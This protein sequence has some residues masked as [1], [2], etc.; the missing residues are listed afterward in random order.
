MHAEMYPE[1]D[2]RS[3]TAPRTSPY[4]T[5]RHVWFTR[6]VVA[7]LGR[8]LPRLGPFVFSSGP[9]LCRD[10]SDVAP[11]ARSP[12]HSYVVPDF[13]NAKGFACILCAAHL[14]RSCEAGDF[15]AGLAALLGRFLPRLGP[16]GPPRG[17][18]YFLTGTRVR[19]R[20][21]A[22]SGAVQ[23]RTHAAVGS[24]RHGA[25]AA[26]PLD[27]AMQH[28]EMASRAGRMHRHSAAARL[29]SNKG[30]AAKTF[31]AMSVRVRTSF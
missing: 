20:Q 13:C 22:C 9:S 17:P 21:Q 28:N 8:F 16:H 15:V 24:I 18:F 3:C 6:C 14:N 2:R 26:A 12:L 23:K 27:I 11:P 5:K 19:L 4:A 25:R 7:H 30:T 29:S 10:A 31:P 1:P